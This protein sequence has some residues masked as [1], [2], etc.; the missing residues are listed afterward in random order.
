MAATRFRTT[1]E[2]LEQAGQGPDLRRGDVTLDA[3]VDQVL[4][5]LHLKP[6]TA[7]THASLLRSRN[8]P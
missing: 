1:P 8:R 5:T 6:S 4:A 7:E 2:G 3:W